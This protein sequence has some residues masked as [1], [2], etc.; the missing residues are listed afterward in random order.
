MFIEAEDRSRILILLAC[1]GVGGLPGGR[2]CSKQLLEGLSKQLVE[3]AKQFGRKLFFRNGI[4]NFKKSFE[5]INVEP[6]TG[7]SVMALMLVCLD[8]FYDGYRGLLAWAGVGRVLVLDSDGYYRRLTTDHHDEDKNITACFFLN[9]GL[10]HG[11]PDYSPFLYRRLPLAFGVSTDGV[12]GKCREDALERF[13]AWCLLE[14]PLSD[15]DFVALVSRFISTN[16]SDN[17][18]MA[19]ALRSE[20]LPKIKLTDILQRTV[21]K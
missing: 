9:D 14:P 3:T 11:G 17:Y 16:I 13:L 5:S 20:R 18:S 19:L 1:D 8:R 6:G 12:H 2:D 10:F 21:S 4:N 7:A 15:E